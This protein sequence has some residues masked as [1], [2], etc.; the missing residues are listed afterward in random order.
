VLATVGENG[1][2][3]SVAVGDA[4]IAARAAKRKLA[5][6]VSCSVHRSRP[7]IAA[8]KS[9][10]VVGKS[11]SLG[12]DRVWGRISVQVLP[13]ART[14]LFSYD[15]NG[16]LAS[17][18]PPG[19]TAHLFGYTPVDETSSYDPPALGSGPTPTAYAYNKDKQ[20]TQVTRPDGQTIVMGYDAAGRLGTITTPTGLTTYS[21]SPTTGTLSSIA[22]PGVGLGYTWDGSLPTGTT[23]SGPVAGS[24]TRTYNADF[25]VASINVAGTA[26]SFT[27]D[28]DRLLTGAGAMTITRDPASG[29]ITG[30]TVGS[31]TTGQT[32]SAFG[33]L[34]STSA[35]F[36]STPLFATS[37]T[38]DALGRITQL[39]ET[40]QG[41]TSTW[42]Y[43]Y[44]AAGQ[45]WKVRRDGV[46]EAEYQYDLNGNRLS[47]TDEFS[48]TTSGTYDAQDRLTSYGSAS[49]TYTLNGELAT[50]TTAAGTSTF[51]YDVL[52]NL[53]AVTLADGTAIEY[54]IDGRS[55]R[56]GK[57][58]GGAL[59]QGFLY[60]DQLRV[61]AEL[62][63]AGAVVSRFVYGTGINVPE[64][65]IKGGVTYRI[66]TDH[67]GSPR[68]LVDV[69]TGT[70][71]QR[72]D[73]DEWGVITNDTS[74][75]FQPFGFA[76]GLY[77]QHT[78]LVRFGARDYD[79]EV[80]RWTTKDPLLF[81]GR[82][83]NVYGYGVDDPVNRTDA[84]GKQSC[85]ICV[86]FSPSPLGIV[87][88][89]QSLGGWLAE[90][91]LKRCTPGYTERRDFSC[92]FKEGDLFKDPYRGTEFY[93]VY[94]CEDLFGNPSE[95]EAELD[96]KTGKCPKLPTK[97]V[98]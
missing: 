45:L 7:A 87:M 32:Y 93:C 76:G 30:T 41:A 84:R 65:M 1:F 88:A 68:L 49:Y 43:E 86:I 44:T 98:E 90:H 28:N 58:V 12:A 79:A 57:K 47:A 18:T 25:D 72:I 63:G 21:Y 40:V 33:E 54:V 14:V 20:L 66:I 61:V 29:F 23:W 46:L 78:K 2:S 5:S 31:V 51:S 73:Y 39:V 92:N 89:M 9:R 26:F 8:A 22:A 70:V 3:R 56:L 55:R 64:Y 48:V 16:N 94:V 85:S 62:D 83:S 6:G 71:A 77:D 74:P 38:R 50:K 96:P 10:I 82:E 81:A 67:L 13:G 80:G 11:R 52:G 27:R 37:Y 35:S 36:G 60:E 75:A 17:V 59:V 69:A 53:R 95:W 24:V 42:N 97:K 19:R 4:R 91:G 34:A 15:A